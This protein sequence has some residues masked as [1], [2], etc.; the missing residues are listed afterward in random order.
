M[1]ASDVNIDNESDP[2]YV[3]WIMIT[4]GNGMEMFIHMLLGHYRH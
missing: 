1:P 4:A 3:L 2:G